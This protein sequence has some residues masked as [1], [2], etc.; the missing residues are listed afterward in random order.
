MR[1]I[2]Q[3]INWLSAGLGLLAA[4]LTAF[5]TILVL[6][7]VFC[8]YFINAATSWTAEVEG[9]LQ[10]ALVMLGG[11]YVLNRGGHVRVDVIYRRFNR[12][13]QELIEILTA[14]TVLL[15]TLPMMWFGGGLAWE[16]W[17]TG[18]VSASAA[19]IVLWPSMATVPLGAGL[20]ALQAIANGASGMLHLFSGG[21]VGND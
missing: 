2:V 14:F 7:E 8:R 17:V 3:V 11:A 19:E 15:V 1:K 21:K 13:K 20:L 4:S 12:E 18:Q 10:I 9:Y 6:Y 5:I 16:A